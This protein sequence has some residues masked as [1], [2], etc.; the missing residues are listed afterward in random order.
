MKKMKTATGSEILDT[1]KVFS[2]YIPLQTMPSFIGPPEPSI[3][4]R[5][6]AIGAHRSSAVAKRVR[7]FDKWARGKS[8]EEIDTSRAVRSYLAAGKRMHVSR[9]VPPNAKLFSKVEI[10][11]SEAI[12]S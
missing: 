7:E 5:I 9:V 10:V 12:G 2:P 8:Q 4:D 3:I 6:A 11:G 1:G